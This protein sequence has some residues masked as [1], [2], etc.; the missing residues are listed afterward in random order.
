MKRP[1]RRSRLDLAEYEKRVLEGDLGA[2]RPLVRQATGP[3]TLHLPFRD[4]ELKAKAD[5][6]GGT[7][8]AFTGY[9]SVTEAPFLMWDWAGDYEEVVNAGAV[10]EDAERDPRRRLLPQP[11]LGLGA[12][13]AHEGR[14]AAA[15]PR[16][17]RAV[18]RGRHRRP[19]RG[20][21]P[22]AVLHGGRRARRDE[23][24]LLRDP[25]DLVAGLL[26]ARTS[27]SRHGR[28]RR[29]GGHAP[30]QP[31]HDRHRRPAGPRRRGA[32]PLEG[33]GHPHR[34]GTGRASRRQG[35]LGRDGL[36]AD[37]GARPGRG[38][39][40]RHGLCA[41]AARRAARGGQPRRRRGRRRERVAGRDRA[42]P[43]GAAHA[44]A[45]PSLP[46]PPERPHKQRN[47]PDLAP[48]PASWAT[49]RGTTCRAP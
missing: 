44:R 4:V 40:R 26:P 30:G 31:G 20:R 29:L 25:A 13:G 37:R 15:R 23:L 41:G 11:R 33:P 18:D 43:R 49:T 19:A 36:D 5:G 35:A 48:E 2:L 27:S 47:T 6:T 8:L 32:G 22:G 3:N 12:D 28:R 10:Q 38:R 34:G 17:H 14:H 24:R 7:R 9:A 16:T 39:R 42:R 1:I 21:L 46:P 45:K